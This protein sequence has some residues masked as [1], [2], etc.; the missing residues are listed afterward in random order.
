MYNDALDC[1]TKA[2]R[3]DPRNLFAL[4]RKGDAYQKLYENDK[5][6]EFYNKAILYSN[7]YVLAYYSKAYLYYLDG[8]F[9]ESIESINK[10]IKL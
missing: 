4:K 6:L 7:E 2:L 1:F 3:L 5:A 8:K 9:N 10:G